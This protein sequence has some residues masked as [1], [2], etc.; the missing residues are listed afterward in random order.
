MTHVKKIALSGVFAGLSLALMWTGS[1][2]PYMDYALPAAAGLLIVLLV[3]ELGPVWP[4]GVYVAASAL[5]ALLLPNK[6]VALLYAMFFGYYPALRYALERKLPKWPAWLCKLAL[7]N[8]TMVAGYYLA[9]FVFKLELS[10]F[11]ETFGRYAAVV[12]LAMGNASFL[13][14]DAMILSSFQVLYIKRWRK[15]LRYLME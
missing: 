9:V 4:L 10:D 3:A 5:S 14:Y 11:G 12:M 8:A 13:L 1:F 2:V 6:M 7:F 15:R